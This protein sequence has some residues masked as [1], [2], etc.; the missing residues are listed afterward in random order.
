MTVLRR[1]RPEDAAATREVF[2]QAVRE[3]CASRYT[4]EERR[5][6]VPDPA[7]SGDWG[8]WLDQHVTLV[9][10]EGGRI[11]GFM[12][13]ERDGYLNM[14]FVRPECMGTGLA[15]RLY[16]ALLEETRGMGLTRLTVL[17]SR[18]AQSFFTRHGWRHA[19]E[20]LDIGGHDLR[21]W[22]KDNPVS[23]AMV[24]DEGQTA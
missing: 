11:T 15:D 1:F 9:A 3:G 22:P 4:E 23:R 17:A 21:A 16:G 6:W 13:I 7:L 24:L 12:M 14:A 2:V 5:A 10:E 20:I 8:P 18:Y 19:P